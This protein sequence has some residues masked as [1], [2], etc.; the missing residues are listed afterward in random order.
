MKTVFKLVFMCPFCFSA[1]S[2]TQKA[3]NLALYQKQLSAKLSSIMQLGGATVLLPTDHLQ[4]LPFMYK[5]DLTLCPSTP[6]KTHFTISEIDSDSYPIP[7]FSSECLVKIVLFW[8]P[9]N[10]N[11]T[12]L[13]L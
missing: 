3:N 13:P 5:Y 1:S 10:K 11:D 12:R 4:C 2:E 8:C 9:A 7:K 6:K